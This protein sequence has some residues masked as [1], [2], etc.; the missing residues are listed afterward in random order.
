MQPVTLLLVWL[1]LVSLACQIHDTPC[2]CSDAPTISSWV[3]CLY[4]T[5]SDSDFPLA[6]DAGDALCSLEDSATPSLTALPISGPAVK[7]PPVEIRYPTFL[8]K[9]QDAADPPVCFD[10]CLMPS[11]TRAGTC[12]PTDTAC[13]CRDPTVYVLLL[14]CLTP[15]CSQ[16]DYARAIAAAD[17]LCAPFKIAVGPSVALPISG[18]E[19]L[20]SLVMAPPIATP[21]IA[22]NGTKLSGDSVF[23]TS[24]E[25]SSGPATPV[26]A[27][28]LTSTATFSAPSTIGTTSTRASASAVIPPTTPPGFTGAGARQSTSPWSL[29]AVIVLGHVVVLGM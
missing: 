26:G 19:T 23:P 17:S 28:S 11:I 14:Q 24:V 1:P 10:M 20:T 27:V 5:C 2:I 12:Q 16:P 22:G 18:I 25:I 21:S 3:N 8:D 13:I 9:R 29:L 4:Y 6:I 7:T 15:A